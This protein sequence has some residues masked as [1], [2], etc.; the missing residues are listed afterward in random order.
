MTLLK[1]SVPWESFV[2][3][4]MLFGIL[5]STFKGLINPI[6]YWTVCLVTSDRTQLKSNLCLG[7]NLA[8]FFDLATALFAAQWKICMH[9][10]LQCVITDECNYFALVTGAKYCDH[11]WHLCVC[12][13]ARPQWEHWIML[14]T[15]GFVGNV[16]FWHNGLYGRISWFYGTHFVYF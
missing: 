14:C 2:E 5:P 16:M 12:W 6:Y 1:K 8:W 13:Y 4:N 10:S 3:Q 15:S 7:Q 9:Q 11:V